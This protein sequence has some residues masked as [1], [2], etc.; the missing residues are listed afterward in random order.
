[1]DCFRKRVYR[2]VSSANHCFGVGAVMSIIVE[3]RFPNLAKHSKRLI[4]A[5]IA[6]VSGVPRQNHI[7]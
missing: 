7:R 5:V 4:F 6:V 2:L 3:E 1:L